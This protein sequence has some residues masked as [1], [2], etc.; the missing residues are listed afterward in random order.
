MASTL[1]IPFLGAVVPKEVSAIM[2]LWKEVSPSEYGAVLQFTM[3]YLRASFTEEEEEK[4][5][6]K[7]LQGFKL[8]PEKAG[9]LFTSLFLILRSAFRTKVPL[10]ELKAGLKSLLFPDELAGQLC[11]IYKNTLE[12]MCNG[13]LDRK[14]KLPTI[15]DCNWR[16]EVTITSSCMKRVM[17]P[18][19][20][21]Q[22]TMSDGTVR[23]FDI[24]VEKF[25]K[26]RYS[27]ANVLRD[28]SDLEK[29]PILKIDK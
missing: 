28:M 25:H 3:E 21:M 13:F 24:D 2:N 4:R 27:V 10:V 22:F 20:F 17:K 5:W 26:L 19:V 11:E 14:I 7:E 12:S 8:S 1:D 6:N 16:T 23:Q 18:S 29:A 9:Q 15:S